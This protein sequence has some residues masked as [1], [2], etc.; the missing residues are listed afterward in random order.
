MYLALALCFALGLTPALAEDI[1][2]PILDGL[3]TCGEACPEP[4]V[5]AMSSDLDGDGEAEFFDI[6]DPEALM[7]VAEAGCGAIPTSAI[8]ATCS[9]PIDAL[10]TTADQQL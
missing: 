5:T 8:G 1:G 2:A 10:T 6:D 3:P 7:D 4:T 9:M